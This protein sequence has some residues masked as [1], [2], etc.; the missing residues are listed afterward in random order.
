MDAPPPLGALGANWLALTGG[1]CMGAE[2]L[3][4]GAAYGEGIDVVVGTE[5]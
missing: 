1:N 5:G 4:D 3:P 2:I